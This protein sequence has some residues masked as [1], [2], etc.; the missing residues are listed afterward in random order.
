MNRLSETLTTLQKEKRKNNKKKPTLFERA[1]VGGVMATAV[2]F[3]DRIW[4]VRMDD[5]N[6]LQPEQTCRFL[7]VYFYFPSQRKRS[8]ITAAESAV[9]SLRWSSCFH[10]TKCLFLGACGLIQL[11]PCLHAA[12]VCREGQM[13]VGKMSC[14]HFLKDS[15]CIFFMP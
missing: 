1:E 6:A 10:F 4:N 8:A 11:W 3:V 14:L 5:F 7:V 9:K 13:G 15:R 2:K 12:E